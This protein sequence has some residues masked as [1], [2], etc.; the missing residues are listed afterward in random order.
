MKNKLP[1]EGTLVL[2]YKEWQTAV[3]DDFEAQHNKQE[4][5]DCGGTATGICY[6]CNQYMECEECDGKGNVWTDRAGDPVALPSTGL[7]AYKKYVIKTFLKLSK[8]TGRS[9]WKSCKDFLNR[10]ERGAL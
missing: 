9:Y 8:F 4:C 3:M 2:N 6:H 1:G 7:L 5:P 10:I